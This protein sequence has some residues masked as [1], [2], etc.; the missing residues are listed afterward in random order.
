MTDVMLIDNILTSSDKQEIQFADAQWLYMNDN[1][2]NGY[3]NY[4][5]VS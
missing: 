1:N 5:Q 3:S 4:I 2:N